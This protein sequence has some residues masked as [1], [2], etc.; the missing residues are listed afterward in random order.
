M[1]FSDGCRCVALWI[2][3]KVGAVWFRKIVLNALDACGDLLSLH[4]LIACLADCVD[5]RHSRTHI[6]K[7]VR[8]QVVG[9]L[10]I[11]INLVRIENLLTFF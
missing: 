4:H 11:L 9:S 5:F 10:A 2:A 3:A 1:P 8:R 6:I 7:L